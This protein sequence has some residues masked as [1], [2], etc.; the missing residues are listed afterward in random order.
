VGEWGSSSGG[1]ASGRVKDEGKYR[2][3]KT[4]PF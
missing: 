2:V 4:N 1:A 3:V